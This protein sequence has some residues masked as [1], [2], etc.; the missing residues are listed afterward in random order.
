[1]T[2]LY[3]WF[4][5]QSNATI[6]RKVVPHLAIVT[7]SKDW[8]DSHFTELRF[9]RVCYL[10]REALKHVDDSIGAGN[11]WETAT[12]RYLGL[13]MANLSVWAWFVVKLKAVG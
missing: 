12:L 1:M 11:I 10:G 3:L 13:D 4:E 2:P 7:I 6:V 8:I 9:I 5:D